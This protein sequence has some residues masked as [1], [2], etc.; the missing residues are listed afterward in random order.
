MTYL[1][2][3][4]QGPLNIHLI[5]KIWVIVGALWV[6]M[7]LRCP[8]PTDDSEINPIEWDR[9]WNWMKYRNFIKWMLIAVP[10]FVVI[11]NT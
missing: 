2:Y 10:V 11:R 4:S 5:I 8:K 7:N 3:L 1:T 6:V 9:Y